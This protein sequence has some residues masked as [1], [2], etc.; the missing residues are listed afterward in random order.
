MAPGLIDPA[1]VVELVPLERLNFSEMLFSGIS[2]LE[3]PRRQSK[4]PEPCCSCREGSERRKACASRPGTKTGDLLLHSRLA[5]SSAKKV[6]VLDRLER[7]P[8]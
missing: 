1:N 7:V 2:C 6:V 4:K 3:G 8:I 5:G